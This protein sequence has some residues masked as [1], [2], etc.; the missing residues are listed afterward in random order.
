MENLTDEIIKRAWD[1]IRVRYQIS[2]THSIVPVAS[3]QQLEILLLRLEEENEAL[4]AFKEGS[5]Q[6]G[7]GS[8]IRSAT[9]TDDPNASNTNVKDE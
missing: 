8:D 9:T 2:T 6:S 5:G 1:L 7:C 4:R 3:L